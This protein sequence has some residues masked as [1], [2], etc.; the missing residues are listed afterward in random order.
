MFKT[1]YFSFV[2]NYF[3]KGTTYLRGI[4]YLLA[5]LLPNASQHKAWGRNQTGSSQTV[6]I[7]YCS[8]VCMQEK[9]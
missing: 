1:S 6:I 4:A 3:L 5:A 8:S 7:L 9:M 2:G